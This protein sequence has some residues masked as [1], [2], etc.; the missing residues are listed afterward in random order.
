[1]YKT[2]KVHVFYTCTTYVFSPLIQ[3]DYFYSEF[4]FSISSKLTIDP[5]YIVF[6]WNKYYSRY[7]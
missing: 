1:M 3:Y 2:R 7:E 4:I 6:I 5:T